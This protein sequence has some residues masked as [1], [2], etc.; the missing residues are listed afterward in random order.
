MSSPPPWAWYAGSIWKHTARCTELTLWLTFPPPLPSTLP[1]QVFTHHL[2]SQPIF[3]S[4]TTPSIHSLNLFQPGWTSCPQLVIGIG[5]GF[6]WVW[7]LRSGLHIMFSDLGLSARDLSPGLVPQGPLYAPARPLPQG[8]QYPIV[9]PKCPLAGFL[10]SCFT[11]F[12]A[13]V[14]PTP[15]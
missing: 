8:P 14:Q 15:L 13:I 3:R 6:C 5:P 12:L 11:G 9:G 2:Q 7:F 1:S 4:R 10:D